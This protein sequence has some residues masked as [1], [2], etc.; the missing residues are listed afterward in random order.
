MS[1]MFPVTEN[2][3]PPGLVTE[4]MCSMIDKKSSNHTIRLT[5]LPNQFEIFDDLLRFVL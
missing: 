4:E 2:L 5:S 1:R 3:I